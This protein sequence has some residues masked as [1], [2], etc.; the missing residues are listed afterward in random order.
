MSLAVAT[1]LLTVP[2][3]P[4]DRVKTIAV[5]IGVFTLVYRW[6][7]RRKEDWTGLEPPHNLVDALYFSATVFSTHCTRHACRPGAIPTSFGKH[8]CIETCLCTV[9]ACAAASVGF[10]DI[11]PKSSRAK[12][13]VRTGNYNHIHDH[14]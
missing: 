12:L 11:S 8:Y 13:T 5:I 3:G 14:D 2:T 6:G 1:R 7:L 4:S 9:G 10:G